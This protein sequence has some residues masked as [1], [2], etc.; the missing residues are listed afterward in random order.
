VCG[1]REHLGTWKAFL[2]K[3]II[4][5]YKKV[6]YIYI[7]VQVSVCWKEKKKIEQNL[8]FK[9]KEP[10]GQERK[11]QFKQGKFFNSKVLQLWVLLG[12]VPSHF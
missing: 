2:K 9:E 10:F 8:L 11:N 1:G 3:L 5:I 4:Y 6:N 7:K 12:K